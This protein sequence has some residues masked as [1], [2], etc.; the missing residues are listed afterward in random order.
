[1]TTSGRGA[2]AGFTTGPGLVRAL[3]LF[4]SFALVISL[5]ANPLLVSAQEESPT[6]TTLSQETETPPLEEGEL[7]TTPLPSSLG[8]VSPQTGATV[9]GLVTIVGSSTTDGFVSSEMAFAYADNPTD[10]W[11]MLQTSEQ[12]VADGTLAVWDTTDLTDGAYNLRLRVFLTDGTFR[13]VVVS[14]VIVGN[15]TPTETPVPTATFP[16][17]WTPAPILPTATMTVTRTPYPTATP[18]PPNPATL[19][20]RDIM[21]NLFYGALGIAILFG[22]YGVVSWLREGRD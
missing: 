15:Y 13:V 21:V 14:G 9:Q 2:Q 1:M 8:I 12:P 4:S 6:P 7:P 17:T 11:F 18:L 22:I 16:P 5:M 10:T 19:S 3:I 20:M